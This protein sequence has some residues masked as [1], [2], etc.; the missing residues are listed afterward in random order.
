[1]RLQRFRSLWGIEPGPNLEDWK[2]LLPKLKA[3]GYAGVEVNMEVI[4]Q[5]SDL[6][7]FK[8]LCEESGLQISALIFSSWPRYTGPRPT[9]LIPT[10]HLK[11]YREQLIRAAVLNPIMINAQSG[12]DYWTVDQSIEFF[13]G[14]LET[15]DEL[16]M[17]GKV[18][19]ETHRNR[20]LFNPYT[21]ASVLEAVP[22]LRI[23]GDFSHWVLVCER[24]LDLGEED[25]ELMERAIPHVYHIHARIG[26][27]QSSQ[28]SDPTNPSFTTEREFFERTWKR[29]I[30]ARAAADSGKE[31][32]V[33][34]FVPEYGPF[35]YHPIESKVSFEAVADSEGQRL[36]GVFQAHLDT[37]RT[38][39]GAF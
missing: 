31:E 11:R 20:S 9:G 5:D 7:L 38:T 32:T 26:S 18:C 8:S 21:T 22:N 23:T 33:L 34:T 39:D 12:A 16:G 2:P 3:H 25:K 14:T 15:D 1:M 4:L 29:V 17:T 36:E 13:K 35:P 24:I 28:C 37:L 27:I 10:L 6:R 30:S 19:H